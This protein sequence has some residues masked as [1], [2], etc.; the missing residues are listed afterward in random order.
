MAR[1][2]VGGARGA[3]ASLAPLALGLLP[4]SAS[5]ASLVPAELVRNAVVD[6][7]V[8]TGSRQSSQDAQEVS[9]DLGRFDATASARA[10]I[11]EVFAETTATYLSEVGPDGVMADLRLESTRT[12][13][14][15]SVFVR[16]NGTL[17]LRLDFEVTETTPFQLTGLARAVDVPAEVIILL[18]EEG[19][20][21]LFELRAGIDIGD[22]LAG[23]D[24]PFATSGTFAA[25]TGYELVLFGVDEVRVPTTGSLDLEAELLLVPEPASGL[26]LAFGL[27]ALASRRRA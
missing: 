1:L 8:S 16:T 15:D 13:S 20:D 21:V 17:E 7:V 12:E 14:P 19:G 18:Q 26:L 5:A 3:V 27:V 23:F 4:L 10:E 25:G 6:S 24:E 22:P 2:R 11:A 9:F